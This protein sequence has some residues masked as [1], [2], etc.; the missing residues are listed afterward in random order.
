V[1]KNSLQFFRVYLK[2][3]FPLEI[4]E[5]VG[6]FLVR[7]V[8]RFKNLLD[9]NSELCLAVRFILLVIDGLSVRIRG[10]VVLCGIGLDATVLG[11]P[12]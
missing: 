6:F 3:D 1:T 11:V 2:V 4:W 7:G 5:F 8:I 12:E 9:G 10:L